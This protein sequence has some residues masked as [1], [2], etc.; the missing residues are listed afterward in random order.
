[1]RDRAYLNGMRDLLQALS[2]NG[3]NVLLPNAGWL[4]W[5]AMAWGAFG[6]SAGMAA[7]TWADR[8]PGPMT[9]PD[10]PARPY[11]EP[12][13]LRTV[14]WH[15]HEELA[16][17]SNYQYCTCPDCHAMGGTYHAALAKRHQLRL[18]HEAAA[19]LAPVAPPLRRAA[20]A[21]RLDQAIAFRD[22]LPPA[23]RAR[24]D[25]EFLDRWRDLV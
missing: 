15:V 22:D 24:A 2:A 18:A 21:A 4:G 1:V 12:Q 9:R 5:L 16:S 6:F 20:V 13:I 19:R 25:A 17:D 23:T 7:G 11:F 14:R 10:E 3:I 8:E